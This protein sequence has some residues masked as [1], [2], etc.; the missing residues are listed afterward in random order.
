[1]NRLLSTDVSELSLLSLWLPRCDGELCLVGVVVGDVALFL[2]EVV[3]VDVVLFNAYVFLL[4]IVH[5]LV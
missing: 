2:V 5:L 3:N 1:M 4:V